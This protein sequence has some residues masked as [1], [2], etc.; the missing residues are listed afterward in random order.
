MIDRYLMSG[1]ERDVNSGYEEF[2]RE[3]L[4]A[5][6]IPAEEIRECGGTSRRFIVRR[7]YG[8]WS[9]RARMKRSSA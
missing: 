9:G 7:R 8:A 1:R 2:F 3:W 6:G 5:A 4:G